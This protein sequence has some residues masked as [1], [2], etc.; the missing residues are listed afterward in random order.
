MHGRE[1]NYSALGKD[2]DEHLKF[3]QDSPIGLRARALRKSANRALAESQSTN[4]LT[5][6]RL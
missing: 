4:D 5:Q 6:P 3:D 1:K 2:L